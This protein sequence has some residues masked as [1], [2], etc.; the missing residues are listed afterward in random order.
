MVRTMVA[1]MVEVGRARM[2][3]EQLAAILASGDRANTPAAAPAC[4]LYL[5]EVRY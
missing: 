4:G 3:A 2:S 5:V 1:A